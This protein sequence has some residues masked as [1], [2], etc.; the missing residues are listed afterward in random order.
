MTVVLRVVLVVSIGF[1]VVLGAAGAAS[2][3][4]AGASSG[5]VDYS[6]TAE[7]PTPLP[8]KFSGSSGGDGW[9]VAVSSTRIFNVF[10]HQTPL[11]VACHIQSSA[12]QCWGGSKTITDG[13]GH[14]FATSYEPGLY[15]DATDG[16][17]YVYA[18]RTSD[19]TG[20]VVCIDTDR[21]A[22]DPGRDFFCGFTPLT[23]VGQAPFTL[24]GGG[25][26][27]SAPVTS[28]HADDGERLVLEFGGLGS[29]R[30][31]HGG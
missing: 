19:S 1:A 31:R 16:H 29:V 24:T 4:V 6:A 3:T 10:H 22:A 30:P 13:S 20:G 8:V 15:F 9:A 5:T 14:N 21:P 18:V 11:Q 28:G 23:A 2:P 12:A 25:D 17:L 26:G 27:P 7:I